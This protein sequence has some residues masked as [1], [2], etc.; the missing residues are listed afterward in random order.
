MQT[1]RSIQR[2]LTAGFAGVVLTLAIAAQASAQT[3]TTFTYQGSLRFEGAPYTGT[4][5]YRFSLWDATTGGGEVGSPDAVPGVS[6]D[7]GL[8]T[9]ELDFGAEAHNAGRYLQIEVRTPAWDGSGDEPAYFTFPDRTPMTAS[10]YAINTRGIFVNEAGDR[11]GVGT[12]Q[13]T[14][15]LHVSGDERTTMLVESPNTAGTWFNLLNTSEGGQFWRMI[16]TGSGNGEGPG[17]L[18]IGHGT[19]AGAESTAMTMLSNGNIGIGTTA[20]KRSLH[21]EGDYYGKGHV[22]LH[23]LEGDG[24]DGTAY[25]QARDDSG[26]S[27]IG[28]RLRTQNGGTINEAI[29]IT[30]YGHVGIGTTAPQDRL[31]I[32]SGALRFPDDTRQT[33]AYRPIVVNNSRASFLCPGGGQVELAATVNGAMPGMAVIITPP[34]RLWNFHTLGYAYVESPN[35]VVWRIVSTAGGDTTYGAATWRITVIP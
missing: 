31:D 12:D 11:V 32:G 16:S 34:Y 8:F 25:V 35:V 5:D 22:W 26:T 17:N 3:A 23:A 33:T 24:A 20:P 1:A 27:S 15:P 13:P 9:A 10:P 29:H 19:Q 7:R 21:N 18:L 14:H 4:A 28:M 30:P 2:R 6:V